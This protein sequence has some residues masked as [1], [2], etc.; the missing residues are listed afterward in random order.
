ME[1]VGDLLNVFHI[2]AS[3]LPV[4]LSLFL[5]FLGLLYW[6]VKCFQFLSACDA[7]PSV[8]SQLCHLLITWR[9]HL[10]GM[11]HTLSDIQYTPH[12]SDLIFSALHVGISDSILWGSSWR[13]ASKYSQ[14]A[15][16]RTNERKASRLAHQSRFVELTGEKTV[17]INEW[18]EYLGKCWTIFLTV[19]AF[20]LFIH[21]SSTRVCA[22]SS[23]YSIYPFS[24]LSRC[25]IKHPK[26]VP[27][28]GNIFMFRQVRYCFSFHQTEIHPCFPLC[29]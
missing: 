4:T 21:H 15:S 22:L 18:V 3:G 17:L 29:L 1:A 2:E 28:L 6:W 7:A 24:V 13:N 26:P 11:Q 14:P 9:K 19:F 10:L 23:R 27:F 5:I 25:G 8:A 12:W 16:E 20:I